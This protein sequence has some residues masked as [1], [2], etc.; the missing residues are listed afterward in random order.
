MKLRLP[1]LM[2]VLLP[3][4]VQVYG[5]SGGTRSTI[6]VYKYRNDSGVMS[7]SDRA[8]RGSRYEVLHYNCFA[9]DLDSQVDWYN[10]PLFTRQ[11]QDIIDQAA[12]R[13]GV[14]PALVRAV[15]H[16]ESAFRPTALSPKGAQGLMQLMPATAQELGVGDAFL[17][18]QNIDG[19]VRYLARLLTQ[20]RG[21]VRLATAAYN[22]GPGAVRRHG[23]VPPFAE[24]RTYIERVGILHRRYQEALSVADNDELAAKVNL[25]A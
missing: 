9:C 22:A 16:A 18:E 2:C 21:D 17:P 7:F 6:E 13:H 4:S 25:G 11:F 19:G 10:T 15:I 12:S 8:P 14:D 3:L 1:L 5:S 24:T 20:H 23:G